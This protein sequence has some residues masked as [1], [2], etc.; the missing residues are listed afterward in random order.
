M[1]ACTKKECA[2]PLDTDDVDALCLPATDS[3]V[4]AGDALAV[5]RQAGEESGRALRSAIAPT[6]SAGWR[7]IRVTCAAG[8]DAVGILSA[9]CRPLAALPLMNVSTLDANFLL[10]EGRHLEA[11]LELLREAG[12]TVACLP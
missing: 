3:R 2:F 11:A 12:S 9:V 6:A 10:V 7:V 8:S 4:L 1:L 5:L